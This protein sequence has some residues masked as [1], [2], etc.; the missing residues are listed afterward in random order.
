MV[1]SLKENNK[2]IDLGVKLYLQKMHTF[3]RLTARPR[4]TRPPT[5]RTTPSPLPIAAAAT[6]TRT[7]AADAPLAAAAALAVA[8]AAATAATRARDRGTEGEEE[9]MMM[10]LKG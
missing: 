1:V 4:K 3:F 2:S 6:T 7:A 5:S 9:G 8:A 10:G